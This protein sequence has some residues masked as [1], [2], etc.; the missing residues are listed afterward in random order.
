VHGGGPGTSI[1][2]APMSQPS[3]VSGTP[4]TVLRPRE[5]ALVR[6]DAVRRAVRRVDGRVRETGDFR[7]E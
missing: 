6:G 3:C 1:S 4:A 2:N 7:I 5:A